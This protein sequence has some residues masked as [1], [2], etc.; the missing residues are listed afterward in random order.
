VRHGR[1]FGIN[2]KGGEAKGI[3]EFA[4]VIVR[5]VKATGCRLA[6]QPGR[7]IAGNAG[8]LASR[9]LYTKQSG[10]KRFLI[11]DTAMNDLIQPALYES[12]HRNGPVFIP[13][14]LAASP[15]DYESAIAG[16]EPWDVVGPVCDSGDFLG[17]DR[18]DLVLQERLALESW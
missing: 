13:D 12:F 10:E 2:Y 5:G 1:G 17:K 11:Q 15:D 9:V 4:S 6:M 7:V 18:S 8:I 3:E 16:T 14:G